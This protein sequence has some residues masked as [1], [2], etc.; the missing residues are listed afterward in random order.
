MIEQASP[1]EV[2]SLIKEIETDPGSTQRT[3]SQKAG[4]SLGKTNYLLKE[5]IKKG[6]IKV[7]HFSR[8]KGKIEKINYI[9]TPK[10]FKHMVYLTKVYIKIKEKEYLKFKLNLKRLQSSGA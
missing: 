2:L 7:N 5:L 3:L 1:E 8:N 10:G 6:F 4:I 9:L